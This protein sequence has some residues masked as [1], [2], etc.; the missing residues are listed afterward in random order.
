MKLIR[1]RGWPI[2]QQL[3]I[4]EQLLRTSSENWCI[5]ND[6]TKEPTIVMGVSGYLSSKGSLGEAL[7]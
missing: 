3:H 2:L 1:L 4:E 5:I 6:G 7:S